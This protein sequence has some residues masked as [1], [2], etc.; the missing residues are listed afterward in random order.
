M[1]GRVIEFQMGIN[2]NPAAQFCCEKSFTGDA[3]EDIY[4]INKCTC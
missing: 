4:N 2:K 1:Y 3:L